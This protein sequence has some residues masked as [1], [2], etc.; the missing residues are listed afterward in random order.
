M[1]SKFQYITLF[2]LALGFGIS[3]CYYDDP[4][5]PPPL[6]IDD[7]S[8]ST[9]VLPTFEKSC[10]TS[11]CH[12][13]T[14]EPNLINDLAYAELLAGGYINIV[15][16]EESILFK[17]VDFQAGVDAMP[18]GGPKLPNIDIEVIKLWIQKGAPNN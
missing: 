7:I 13:G 9:H 4:P 12:D 16:P 5:E 1:K 17:T 3:S 18:P 8:F 2:L 11:N 14:S 6:D 15:I 10:S